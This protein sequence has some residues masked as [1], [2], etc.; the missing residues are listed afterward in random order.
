ML[1]KDSTLQLNAMDASRVEKKLGI[2]SLN[3]CDTTQKKGDL[4]LSQQISIYSNGLC[5]HF[6]HS[7]DQ[8]ISD[9][10][11]SFNCGVIV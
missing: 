11:F 7:H 10:F 2:N 6:K 9:S 3:I 4:G 1:K 8:A 5:G